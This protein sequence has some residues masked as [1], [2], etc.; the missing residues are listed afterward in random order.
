MC[1]GRPSPPGTSRTWPGRR[2]SPSR[3]KRRTWLPTAR[4]TLLATD[5]RA[6]CRARQC[7]VIWRSRVCLVLKSSHMTVKQRLKDDLTLNRLAGCGV[8]P[9]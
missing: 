9:K 3:L 7:D 6:P 5:K 4:A 2:S 1:T 8:T